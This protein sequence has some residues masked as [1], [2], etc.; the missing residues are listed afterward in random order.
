MAQERFRQTGGGSFFGELIYE[1]VVPQDHFLRRLSE[2][3]D[4]GHWSRRLARYY[5]GG[6]EYGPIPYEPALLLKMLLI[7]YLY[8]LSERQPEEL[9]NDSLS[10]K[11]FLGLGADERAPDHSTLSV[12]KARLLK[13]QGLAAYEALLRE[14]VR[15]AQ[16]K[17]IAFGRVQVIDSTASVAD[18]NTGKDKERR[19]GGGEP[20]DPDARWGAKGKGPGGTTRY[21]HGYKQHVSLN[22]TTG[23][24]TS[25]YHTDGSA[26][27]GHYLWRLIEHDQGQGIDVGLVA[28]DRGYDD[29]DNH[30]YLETKGIRDAICLND[31]R[32]QKK[33]HHRSGWLALRASAEYA[34][35]LAE[36]YKI[37]RKF[38]EMK[39][40]HGLGR[41]RY[42]GLLR[43]AIQGYLTAMAVN[44]KRIVKLLF[45]V[46]LRN[47]HYTLAPISQ[48][49]V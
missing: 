33:D 27:D 22:A 44:L 21:F 28:A 4:W 48:P 20:H 41:C 47:Q 35:G 34:A 32:T 31:Y 23:L 46:S 6:A 9:S 39:T 11:C 24:I 12:F 3:V 16:E 14:V 19:Q 10:V 38:G 40:R 7:A 17:G 18:V 13:G 49:L 43:Y 25:V 15:L 26:Y 2:V 1:R 37:E 42:V 8:N 36:H 29:G 45:G 30:Y 5:Q